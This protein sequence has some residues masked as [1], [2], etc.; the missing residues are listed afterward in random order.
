MTEQKSASVNG[1]RLVYEIA[2]DPASPPAVLLHAMGERGS[3]WAG[4]REALTGRFRVITPDLRGHGGSDW[5]GSYSFRLMRDDVT[6]LLDHLGFEAVTLVG[7]SL[8]GIVAFAV[9]MSQPERI[10]RLIIEDVTPPYPSSRPLPHRPEGVDLAFDWDMLVATRTE[11]DA[12][13]PLL[14]AGLADITAPT[15]LIGGGSESHVP[16][17]RLAEAAALLPRCDLVTIQAG[18]HVHDSAP[19]EFKGALLGWLD[20]A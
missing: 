7:H 19:E 13:D 8:G 9:A 18:H 17:E 12:G 1:I 3:D 15:L 6:G 4:V 11:G 16:G 14:W 5:P 20:A 10:T 2:G